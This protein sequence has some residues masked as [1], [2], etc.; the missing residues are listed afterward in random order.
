MTTPNTRSTS[1]RQRVAVIGGG[2]SGNLTARLLTDSC[3]VRLYESNDYVGGHANTVEVELAGSRFQVDTG[4]MVFNRRTYPNFCEMLRLLEVESRE[5][6]MSFSVRCDRTGLEY[7]GSGLNGLFAQR[8]NLF[9]PRFL[10][11][12]S[13]IMRFNRVATQ[14]AETNAF[15]AG[16]TVRDFLDSHRL[17]SAFRDQYF[18]PMTAAIWSS[19]PETMLDAP[20]KFII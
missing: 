10:K 6:D 11:M 13:D 1:A 12:L 4:F 2:I 16:E 17:G 7:E 19:S 8:S 14:A 9:R 18:A 15:E 3:E 5:S 20:A